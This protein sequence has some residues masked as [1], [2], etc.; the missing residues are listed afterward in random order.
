MNTSDKPSSP[1]QHE[2]DYSIA[3]DEFDSLSLNK[4]E[5][6][7]EGDGKSGDGDGKG[8]GKHKVILD[9]V[10]DYAD[11]AELSEADNAR[12]KLAKL[13]IAPMSF[14]A[15]GASAFASE[16]D[17]SRRNFMAE[18]GVVNREITIRDIANSDFVQKLDE[19]Q[20]ERRRL[21]GI[22]T[23]DEIVTGAVGAAGAAIKFVSN[24]VESLTKDKREDRKA[25]K[26][27]KNFDE[28]RSVYDM[29]SEDYSYSAASLEQADFP[30]QQG[31]GEELV[32]Q[33]RE[34]LYETLSRQT[35]YDLNSGKIG[36]AQAFNILA[37]VMLVSQQPVRTLHLSDDLNLGSDA[38][39]TDKELNP[40]GG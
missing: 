27:A 2:A 15:I 7:E 12:I 6:D 22:R 38:P 37:D 4:D 11:D 32:Q 1:S 18:V 36:F 29:D 34:E 26:L 30:V 10:V 25:S 17:L 40:M 20:A 9:P 14:L 21:F 16:N 19:K 31:Q 39:G 33:S 35:Q 24:A 8:L 28:D 5:D 3:A 13:G 23:L